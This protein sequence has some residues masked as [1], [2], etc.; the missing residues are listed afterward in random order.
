MAAGDM[1][2]SSASISFG[3]V[4]S[5]AVKCKETSNALFPS[6]SKGFCAQVSFG[7]GTFINLVLEHDHKLT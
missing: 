2:A 1:E 4:G 5:V 7:N 3:F 6:P